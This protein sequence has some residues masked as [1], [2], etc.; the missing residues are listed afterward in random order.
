MMVHFDCDWS[1][2]VF[3]VAIDHERS[4]VIFYFGPL[5]VGFQSHED[6]GAMA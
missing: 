5:I 1:A 2:C 4:A 6:W 3:G